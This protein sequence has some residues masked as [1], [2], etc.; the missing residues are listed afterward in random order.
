MQINSVSA[1]SF[2][3]ILDFFDGLGSRYLEGDADYQMDS[4]RDEIDARRYSEHKAIIDNCDD[5]SDTFEKAAD[6]TEG[7]LAG[8]PKS[9]HSDRIVRQIRKNLAIMRADRLKPGKL[10]EE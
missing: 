5:F 9:V 7:I 1:A 6:N 4:I 10:A 3:G 8:I 2:R